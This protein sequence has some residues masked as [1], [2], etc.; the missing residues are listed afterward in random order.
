V[1]A[2]IARTPGCAIRPATGAPRLASTA[3]GLPDDLRR[4]F[5]LCG[6][7]A[8]FPERPFA[9][10]IPGPDGL[11]PSNPILLGSY[12]RDNRASFDADRSSFWYLIAE[13]AEEK[14]VIDLHPARRGWCYD[15]FHEV[16]ATGNSAVLARSFTDLLV[17]LVATAGE[18]PVWKGESFRPL[19]HAYDD[20]AGSE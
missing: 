10:S 16:Y 3:H 12:Y 11:L 4:F 14:V 15:A 20:A 9:W 18:M 6:G 1:I 8:L 7:V 2:Q 5:E 19:G 17:A 13:S